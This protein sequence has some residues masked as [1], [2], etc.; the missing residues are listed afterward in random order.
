MHIYPLD[1]HP[2]KYVKLHAESIATKLSSNLLR[3]PLITTFPFRLDLS[4]V[5]YSTYALQ[6]LPYCQQDPIF[7][8]WRPKD[9]QN[10]S[11]PAKHPLIPIQPPGSSKILRHNPSIPRTKQN[12][13]RFFQAHKSW[14][15]LQTPHVHASFTS[16]RTIDRMAVSTR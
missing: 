15:S 16:V 6:S 11:T 2:L 5:P 9:H 3:S 10:R 13:I 12:G 7:L 1:L 4:R 8:S 14:P